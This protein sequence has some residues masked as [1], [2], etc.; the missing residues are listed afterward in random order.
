MIPGVFPRL[1]GN[2]KEGALIAAKFTVGGGG[3]VTATFALKTLTAGGR[4]L[5]NHNSITLTRTAVGVITLQLKG[6]GPA[7]AQNRGARDM[8]L[9]AVTHVPVVPGTV[10]NHYRFVPGGPIIEDNGS[11]LL[12][13]ITSAG[14]ISGGATEL[15][16]ANG[17]EV[18]VSIYLA[19]GI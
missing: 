15:T 14:A 7:T 17:D 19:G 4:A 12:R 18:H 5:Q 10:G 16:L 11:Q 3:G 6:L 8:V 2:Y 13:T 9:L 1:F